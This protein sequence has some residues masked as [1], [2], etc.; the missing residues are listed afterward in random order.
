MKENAKADG[1]SVDRIIILHLQ[2]PH[3][4][5][6]DLVDMPGAGAV[7]PRLWTVRLQAFG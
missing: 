4:P 1:V 3:V 6:I 2:N 5:S 7:L